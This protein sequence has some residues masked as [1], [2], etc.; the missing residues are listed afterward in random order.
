MGRIQHLGKF[1]IFLPTVIILC[2]YGYNISDSNGL[3]KKNHKLYLKY[4]IIILKQISCFKKKSKCITN[5]FPTFQIP[6]C[7]LAYNFS[8]FMMQNYIF[9]CVFC[10]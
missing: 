6:V 1:D 3:I 10:D 4:Y 5:I 9:V 7:I 8:A 2:S